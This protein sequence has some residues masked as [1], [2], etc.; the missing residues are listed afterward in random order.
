MHNSI[1][2]GGSQAM[3]YRFRGPGAGTNTAEGTIP[4]KL[5]A[6]PWLLLQNGLDLA[7]QRAE[8]RVELGRYAI[9][10]LA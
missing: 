1:R 7:A 2:Y 8:A 9:H 5:F 6:G 4:Y 3:T 10:P